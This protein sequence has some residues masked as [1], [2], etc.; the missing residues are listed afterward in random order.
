MVLGG[1][2]VCVCCLDTCC[3]VL[4]HSVFVCKDVGAPI[5][6]VR[7]GGGRAHFILAY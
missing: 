2:Y 3:V 4:L 1:V 6:K 7:G 5:A